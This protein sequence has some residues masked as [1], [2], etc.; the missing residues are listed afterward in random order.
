MSDIKN[1]IICR[2]DATCF[3]ANQITNPGTK[4]QFPEVMGKGVEGEGAWPL[5]FPGQKVGQ[6]PL[7]PKFSDLDGG[8]SE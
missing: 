8:K 4:K 2:D 7:L 1:F 3:P 5:L 6:A